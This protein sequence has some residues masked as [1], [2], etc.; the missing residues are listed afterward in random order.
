MNYLAH[1]YLSRNNT[2][3]LV[4]NFIADHVRG[5]RF[6]DYSAGITDGIQLHRQIDTFTDSH[7][8]FR[9]AKRVFYN[10]FERYSGVLVDIFFDHLLAR[11]FAQYS[12][13]SLP[14]FS[15]RVYAVYQAHSHV[16]PEHSRHFLSYVLR[17]DVYTAYAS[18]EGIERVLFH[19]SQRINKQVQLH[20]AV[21]V[22]HQSEKQ[23]EALFRLFFAD[24][25]QQFR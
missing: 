6:E 13:E 19:L 1:A 3:L 21:K 9:E 14:L 5:N 2:E 23:L 11:N 7:E 8:R 18:L 4:G 22:F 20:D 12:T 24:A 25:L 16:L 17:N 15:A 10:G